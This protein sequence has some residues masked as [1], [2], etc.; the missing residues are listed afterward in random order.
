MKNY[1][2]P[3]FLL[4]LLF[5]FLTANAQESDSVNGF[6]YS[7]DP[8]DNKRLVYPV[9]TIFLLKEIHLESG[10]QL[11]Y[12]E[13]EGITF[14]FDSSGTFKACADYV[15]KQEK[16]EGDIVLMIYEQGCS[17]QK[18]EKV[19]WFMSDDGKTLRI[20]MYPLSKE[21]VLSEVDY[22]VTF[23]APRKMVLRKI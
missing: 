23:P 9:D 22:Q 16:Y 15:Q 19:E 12:S 18:Y 7:P 2:Y 6:W 14:Q 10:P 21:A 8:I 17:D 1:F 5:P 3:A 4:L 20:T 11:E 13:L